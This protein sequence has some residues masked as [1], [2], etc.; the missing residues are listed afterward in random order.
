MLGTYPARGFVCEGKNILSQATG[1]FSTFGRRRSALLTMTVRAAH[2]EGFI[3]RE[4]AAGRARRGRQGAF[5]RKGKGN[6]P[7][8]R[9]FFI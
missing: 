3:G 4:A 6:A 2:F 9:S 8:R 7:A 5:P 1:L